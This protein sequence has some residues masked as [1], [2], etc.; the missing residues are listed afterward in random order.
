MAMDGSKHRLERTELIYIH[1]YIFNLVSYPRLII[2]ILVSNLRLI[3][4]VQQFYWVAL[5]IAAGDQ[6]LI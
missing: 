6:A 3:S 1:I 5:L 2:I 4:H